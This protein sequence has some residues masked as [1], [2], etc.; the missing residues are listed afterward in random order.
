MKSILSKGFLIFSKSTLI[1]FLLLSMQTSLSQE[2]KGMYVDGFAS[3]LG[4]EIKEDSLLQFAQNNGFNY[5][6]L[7]QLHVV[8]ANTPLA[9]FNAASSF[10]NF[11]SK[12]KNQYG[13]LEIGAAG[14]N[15]NSFYNSI[16]QYNLQHP[17]D[18]QKVD[19]FN[20]EFEYWNTPAVSSGGYYCDSYL[21]P[22]SLPCDTSGGFI[23]YLNTLKK[24]DSLAAITNSKSECYLGWFNQAHGAQIAACGVDRILLHIYITSANYSPSYQFNYADTRL[25]NLVSEFSTVD[26]MPIYSSETDFMY[27]FA[28]NNDFYLPFQELETT[29]NS[30]TDN[31]KNYINLIGIQWFAYSYLP[32]KNL[33]LGL[34]ISDFNKLKIY[35]N[36]AT[37]WLVINDLLQSSTQISVRDL[38]GTL[39]LHKTFNEN[40]LNSK[41]IKFDVSRLQFGFYTIEIQQDKNI[42][43]K[44]FI[45]N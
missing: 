6:T 1:G 39:V 35:P 16:H 21:T 34:E 26:V 8:N 3:I 5:L 13:I 40:E 42:I 17:A 9:D 43:R 41:N 27:D 7:Y 18:S 23:Y 22:N 33:D 4:D 30:V 37:D 29:L 12:A 2:I 14:E 15:Y 38:N 31:W 24:I 19:V 36:P 11:I 10:A 20:L 32:K 45:K 25:Q 44:T 28:L